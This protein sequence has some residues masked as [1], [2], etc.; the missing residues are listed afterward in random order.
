MATPLILRILWIDDELCSDDA[1]VRL[2][3]SEDIFVDVATTGAEGLCRG[4]ANTYEAILL[5]LN[6]PDMSGLTVMQRFATAGIRTPVI[7]VSGQYLQPEV[8]V[9]AG[10]LGAAAVLHKP[11]FGA[12][13]LAAAIRKVAVGRAAADE[14]AR[15]DP[16]LG[17]VAAYQ[18]SCPHQLSGRGC[19]GPAGSDSR[20][21][22]EC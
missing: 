21:S 13:E 19:R 3:A 6:L 17:I 9:D 15:P 2:L 11:L 14:P 18:H 7:I 16:P 5:D 8:E 10:R 1:L 20:R 22:V 4:L 12:E